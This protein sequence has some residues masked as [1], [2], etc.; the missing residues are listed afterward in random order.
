M[1][2]AVLTWL[3]A[4][5]LLGVVTGLRTMTP[6][7]VLC[8]FAYK[9]NLPV[10][11]TWAFWTQ[12]LATAIVFT[13]LAAGELIADKLPRTPNR[14]DLGPLLARLA[15]GGLVG[16]IAATSLDGSLVEGV[17]LGVAGAL[18]GAFGGY[19]VRRELVARLECKDWHVAVAEDLLAVGCAVLA[20][21]V[22]TG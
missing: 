10:D 18:L 20:I 8:W 3:V 5:P 14:T 4:I 16:A 19:L 21:G 15:F 2:M 11:G 22:V 13:V 7:V 17:F 12:R 9:G 6:M 1:T